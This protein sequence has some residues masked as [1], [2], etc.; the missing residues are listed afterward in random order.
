MKDGDVDLFGL[1]VALTDSFLALTQLFI[2]KV[3][4]IGASFQVNSLSF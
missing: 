2:M 1:I 3:L 4:T